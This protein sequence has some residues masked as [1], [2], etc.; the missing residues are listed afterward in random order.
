MQQVLQQQTTTIANH[1]QIN[2]AHYTVCRK[3]LDLL[4]TGPPNEMLQ[5]L[6]REGCK[7]SGPQ[8]D[9]KA[10]TLLFPSLRHCCRHEIRLNIIRKIG[11]PTYTS[12]C[13]TP[14]CPN[15]INQNSHHS[16]PQVTGRRRAPTGLRPPR[17]NSSTTRAT[18]RK[19]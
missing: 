2:H 12:I 10:L 4:R 11:Q 18:L 9:A 15:A 3:R 17:K 14:N 19:I 13:V 1:L 8:G 5:W 7:Q 16:T 6:R